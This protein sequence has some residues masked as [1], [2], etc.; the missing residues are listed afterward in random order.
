MYPR[1][2]KQ[3]K[4]YLQ[5]TK[6]IL[7][8]HHAVNTKQN[9]KVF[10]AVQKTR[11]YSVWLQHRH[12]SKSYVFSDASASFLSIQITDGPYYLAD[13]PLKGFAGILS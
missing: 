13:S 5:H 8:V 11:G 7:K 3:I 10:H 4:I 9:L 6:Q 1:T 12:S 2:R